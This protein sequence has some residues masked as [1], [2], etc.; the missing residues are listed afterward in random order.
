MR[1][2]DAALIAARDAA[3]RLD[4]K[5][6]ADS[7]ITAGKKLDQIPVPSLPRNSPRPWHLWSEASAA[8]ATK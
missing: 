6:S 4:Y 1:V 8:S 2:V 3:L 5:G 7:L